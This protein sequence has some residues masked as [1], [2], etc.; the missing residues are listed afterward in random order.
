M[1]SIGRSTFIR[2]QADP[3]VPQKSELAGSWMT[4][5]RTPSSST[6]TPRDAGLATHINAG[7]QAVRT[8]RIG[9]S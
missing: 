1:A 4:H 3:H 7:K 9:T 6:P 2:G 5:K 8:A